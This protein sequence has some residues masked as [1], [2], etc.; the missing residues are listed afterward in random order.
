MPEHSEE[1][2]KQRFIQLL[3][4]S[5]WDTTSHNPASSAFKPLRWP[6]DVMLHLQGGKWHAF[7]TTPCEWS[8]SLLSAISS[9]SRRKMT[10]LTDD[11]FISRH[12]VWVNFGSQFYLQK[13]HHF[14]FYA[15]VL[16]FTPSFTRSASLSLPLLMY[17]SL[18]HK[19]HVSL[20][21][22]SSQIVSKSSAPK[23]KILIVIYSCVHY[24]LGI[25][26][27][28]SCSIGFLAF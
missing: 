22:S 20:V 13:V 16:K 12:Q 23:K 10:P 28:K 26:Q 3:Q 1:V 4:N 2:K 14:H 7:S 25:C 17:C 15:S 21:A 5:Y 27:T 24:C 19:L 18:G 6:A 11:R 9:K 8:S